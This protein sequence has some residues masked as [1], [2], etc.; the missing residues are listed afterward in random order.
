MNDEIVDFP[1]SST[2]LETTM[3]S[4][5]AQTP[6]RAAMIGSRSS[7]RSRVLQHLHSSPIYTYRK[8]EA[9]V[10][11][12]SVLSYPPILV[13][14]P[15]K[16]DPNSEIIPKPFDESKYRLLLQTYYSRTLTFTPASNFTYYNLDKYSVEG[17]PS[18]WVIYRQAELPTSS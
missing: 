15:T 5:H 3:E 12:V 7:N 16:Q 18:S 14:C 6:R 13:F 11:L 8:L 4:M 17:A 1:D 2:K 10:C 9:S